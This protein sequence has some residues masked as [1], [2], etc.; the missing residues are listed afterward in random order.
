MQ[1]FPYG[2]SWVEET[3]SQI[4]F[5]YKFTGKELDPE[6]GLYYFG[7]RY[8]EPR[9]SVWISTDP[10]LAKY[11][12][13][14]RT[15]SNNNSIYQP[16]SL[17]LFAYG[18]FNPLKFVDPNGEEITVSVSG[19]NVNI[20]MTVQASGPKAST[21]NVQL[22]KTSTQKEFS[23]NF[24]R[25]TVRTAVD[26][27]VG[28][29]ADLSRHQ[30]SMTNET[31][32]SQ[33]EVGG[34][35]ATMRF[36]GKPSAQMKKELPHEVGHLFGLGDEYVEGVD[37]ATGDRVTTPQSGKEDSLMATIKPDAKISEDH[38]KTIINKANAGELNQGVE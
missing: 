25:Y 16:A 28:G 7:A 18:G 32:A 4:Y 21:A 9:I 26:V 3:K 5:P 19:T 30:I 31:P 33:A 38:V 37:P 10:A 1:Y 24:G 12:E 20:H 17:S 8:Y 11:I 2:E 13:R 15:S 27:Q 35:E 6:T 14:T 34:N 36:G 29:E 23:G 22:F